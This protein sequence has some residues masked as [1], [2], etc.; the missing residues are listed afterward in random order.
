MASKSKPY[1]VAKNTY[2]YR[3]LGHMSESELKAIKKL[4]RDNVTRNLRKIKKAGYEST[5]ATIGLSKAV[6]SGIVSKLPH[7]DATPTKASKKVRTSLSKMQ[8][9]RGEIFELQKFQNSSTGTVS[10]MQAFETE[11]YARVGD[12]YRDSSEESKRK[13]WEL[14]DEQRSMIEDNGLKSEE[15]QKRLAEYFSSI[16]GKRITQKRS[17]VWEDMVNEAYDKEFGAAEGEVNTSP[18]PF[19][20]NT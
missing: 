9:L 1:R 11:T 20:L 15:L 14:Y 7:L 18:S 19:R 10:G 6:K 8:L 17:K 5:P 2:S 13:F 3:E 12:A 16:D 4:L